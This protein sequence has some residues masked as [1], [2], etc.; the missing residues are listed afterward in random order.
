M[1][2]VLS[3]VFVGSQTEESHAVVE[4]IIGASNEAEP[5]LATGD[6]NGAAHSDFSGSRHGI[7]QTGGN[8]SRPDLKK[9]TFRSD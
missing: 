9:K 5:P 4:L 1:W 3:V 6:K 8:G 7:G 2:V